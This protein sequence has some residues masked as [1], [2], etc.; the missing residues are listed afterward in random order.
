MD[1]LGKA[2][3]FYAQVLGLKLSSKDSERHLF[4]ECD[5][6][7]LLLFNPEKTSVKS[8]PVPVHGAKGP[9]HVAFKIGEDEFDAWRQRLVS[10]GVAIE[11][12]I[13]W[14]EGSHSIYFRDP[15]GNSLEFTTPK[16]WNL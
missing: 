11:T 14:P 10:A 7:M 15:A 8:G 16:T 3:N 1:D 12:E 9:G 4:L 5:G 13:D 6:Q 2:E